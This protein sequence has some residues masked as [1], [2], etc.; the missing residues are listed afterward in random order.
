MDE[1]PLTEYNRYVRGMID[2]TSSYYSYYQ[3]YHDSI[4]GVWKT[5]LMLDNHQ[6]M[7][8]TFLILV[9]D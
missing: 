1:G 9:Q 2:F 5:P 4:L 7:Y 8:S 6:L 3:L